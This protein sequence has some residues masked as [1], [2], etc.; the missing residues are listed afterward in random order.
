[1]LS[2]ITI[3]R[4][5]YGKPDHE[6]SSLELHHFCGAT[7]LGYGTSFYLRIAYNRWKR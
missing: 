4:C 1:M 5:Y 3:P 6:G 7:E 2:E